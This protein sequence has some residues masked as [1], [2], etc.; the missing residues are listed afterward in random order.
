MAVTVTKLGSAGVAA[1]TVLDVAWASADV[2]GGAV[3]VTHGLNIGKDATD[4]YI[5]PRVYA[6]VTVPASATAYYAV[7]GVMN[8]TGG[9]TGT[10]SLVV[11]AVGTPTTGRALVWIGA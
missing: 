2:S 10:L 1:G 6:V 3:S 9:P 8:I 5:A 4:A 11:R 7:D